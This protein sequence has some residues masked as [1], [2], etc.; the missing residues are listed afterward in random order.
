MGGNLIHRKTMESKG[1]T[2]I[3]TR[4]DEQTEFVTSIDNWFRP[5][6]FVNAPD[7]T[8]YLLDMYRETIE[9]PFSIPE[10]I[11]RHLDLESGYDRGRIYRLVHPE[12]TKY[13]VQ[14]LGDLPVDQL[15]QQLESPNAG[16]GK[17][18]SG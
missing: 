13:K 14:K 2:Y 15:V 5:V 18:H 6:N 11:K 17:Q 4:A 10:D 8:L 12:G 7:G 1:A 3:A 9:H 16:T